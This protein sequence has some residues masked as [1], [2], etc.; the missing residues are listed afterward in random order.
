[1]HPYT[2]HGKIFYANFEKFIRSFDNLPSENT[3]S[4][5]VP[6]GGYYSVNV[7]NSKNVVVVMNTLFMSPDSK[8]KGSFAKD[9][10][11]WLEKKLFW[12]RKNDKRITVVMHRYPGMHRTFAS[13]S[14]RSY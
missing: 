13:K 9:Q 14:K 4:E 6:K 12:A 10:M 8:I 7:P 11:H 5:D 3:I 1:V 2:E